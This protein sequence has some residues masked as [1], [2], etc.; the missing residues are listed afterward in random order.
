MCKKSTKH[1]FNKC[2]LCSDL[3]KTNRYILMSIRKSI[4]D[5]KKKGENSFIIVIIISIHIQNFILP[6]K[7]ML[8]L[9]AQHA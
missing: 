2:K 4:R 8:S 1:V 7:P 9:Y 6:C 5:S 3:T